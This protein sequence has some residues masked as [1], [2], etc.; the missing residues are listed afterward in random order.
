MAGADGAA[1]EAAGIRHLRILADAAATA[2]AAPDVDGVLAAVGGA[3]WD[4]GLNGHLALL[5]PGGSALV[6]RSVVLDSAGLAQVER[7]LG[8]AMADARIDLDVPTPYQQVV[9]TG[10]A[11][12]VEAPLWWARLFAPPL[13]LPEATAVADLI[14]LGEVALVPIVAGVSVLGVLTTWAWRLSDGDV[15]AAE[16]L[17]QTAGAVLRR[18]HGSTAG[19]ARPPGLPSAT[20]LAG[21]VRD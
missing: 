14:R 7:V 21:A 12:R 2:E 19:G 10:R 5:E 16:L 20:P 11:L 3:L 17:G 8:R 1:A 9:H 13:G 18:R 4:L 15:A 6:I